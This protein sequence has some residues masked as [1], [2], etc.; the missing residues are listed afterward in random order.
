MNQ[1]SGQ[2]PRC[3]K[4]VAYWV[5]GTNSFDATGTFTL[6]SQGYVSAAHEDMASPAIGAGGHRVARH[7]RHT[8]AAV[9]GVL[10]LTGNRLLS[11]HCLRR[12]TARVRAG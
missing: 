4:A 11:E 1:R 6:T 10:T 9:I 7:C 8:F 3:T 5:S 2:P 12:L